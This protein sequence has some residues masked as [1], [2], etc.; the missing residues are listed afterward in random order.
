MWHLHASL[1][2]QVGN[3]LFIISIWISFF[4]FFFGKGSAKCLYILNWIAHLLFSK[5]FFIYFGHSLYEILCF[6]CIF[7]HNDFFYF[8]DN[9]LKS[10][11]TILIKFNFYFPSLCILFLKKYLSSPRLQGCIFFLLKT[12]RSIVLEFTFGLTVVW[13]IK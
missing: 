9:L 8:L 10:R 12:R 3:H 6:T 4:F 13:G 1:M 2:A 5:V 7:P 11:S